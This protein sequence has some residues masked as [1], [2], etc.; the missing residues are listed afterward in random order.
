MTKTLAGGSAAGR[1]GADWDAAVSAYNAT[2]LRA[3]REV[4]DQVSR[5]Q[6]LERQLTDQQRSL[7]AAEGAYR[8][9]EQRYSAGLASYL[10]VLD[11]EMQVLDARRL[12][13]QLLAD[14]TLARV[15]LLVALGGNFQETTG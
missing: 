6:S 14:R 12:Q 9:A 7:D 1:A 11:A 4:A 2:V 13:V 3:V 15:A 10:T 5:V 8:L